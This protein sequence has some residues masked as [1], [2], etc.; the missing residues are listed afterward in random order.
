[1]EEGPYS[2]Y[3][4]NLVI[5]D[6]TTLRVNLMDHTRLDSILQTGKQLTDFL[7]VPFVDHR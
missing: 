7:R 1:M 6:N 2:S 4:L 5:D 3:Q